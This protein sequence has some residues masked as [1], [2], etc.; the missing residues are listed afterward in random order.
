MKP[1]DG[2]L[3]PG[4]RFVRGAAVGADETRVSVRTE[5]GVETVAYDYLVI[6]CGCSYPAPIR[7]AVDAADQTRARRLAR[8]ASAEAT[9]G[10]AGAVLVVG[11]G[12]VGVEVAAELAT[13]GP[14]SVTLA[15]ARARIERVAAT[16]RP[17]IFRRDRVAATPRLP[18][19]WSGRRTDEAREV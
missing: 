3:V 15:T 12:A 14:R 7:E 16:P 17:R 2:S 9:L 8:I 6:A 10:G 5:R 13:S 4:A 11:G 1:L 19:G 18:R